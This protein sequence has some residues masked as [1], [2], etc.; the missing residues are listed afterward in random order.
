MGLFPVAIQKYD[1]SVDLCFKDVSSVH[2]RAIS[3]VGGAAR[4]QAFLLAYSDYFLALGC[5]LLSSVFA[6]SV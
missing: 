1:R 6:C 2:M 3:A 4:R 5:V